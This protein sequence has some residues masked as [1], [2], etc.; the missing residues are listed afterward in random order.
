VSKEE[1]GESA[2]EERRGVAAEK[3]RGV[4][5]QNSQVQG[6]GIRIYR[7]ALGLGFQMGQMGWTW[8]KTLGRAALNIF[9]NINAPADFVCT[10]NRAS[11]CSIEQNEG[12][13]GP[14]I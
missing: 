3:I 4:G 13:F 12:L 5:V 9:R 2:G 11:W 6:R 1:E 10:Q 14:G 7:G 8:P